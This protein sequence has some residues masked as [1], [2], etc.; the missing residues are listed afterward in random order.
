MGRFRVADDDELL[1]LMAFD[2]QP[3]LATP[4]GI[5]RVDPLGDDAFHIEAAGAWQKVG[6]FGEMFAVDY[7]AFKRRAAEQGLQA[8]FSFQQGQARQILAIEREQVKDVILQIVTTL[9]A[10]FVLKFREAGHAL[11]GDGDDLAVKDG[12][13]G[14]ERGK[15]TGDLGIFLGPVEAFA[16]HQPHL[17]VVDQRLRAI[18]VELD[19]VHPLWP[20]RNGVGERRQLQ[21]LKGQGGQLGFRCLGRRGASFTARCRLCLG[22]HLVLAASRPLLAGIGGDLLHGP[23]GHDTGRMGFQPSF[24]VFVVRRFVAVFD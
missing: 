8:A 7:A 24:G 18:A 23:P 1:T 2:L 14:I 22:R 20:R 16:R 17:A 4:A 15:D 21:V 9:G 3:G 13:P 12:L 19:L 11:F 5:H 10:E 6:V